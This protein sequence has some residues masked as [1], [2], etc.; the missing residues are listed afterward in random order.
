[1]G[2]S[3]LLLAFLKEKNNFFE[4]LSS[5]LAEAFFAGRKGLQEING[6]RRLQKVTCWY[7]GDFL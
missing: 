4:L 5:Y 7:T 3:R 1:V 6:S 2:L